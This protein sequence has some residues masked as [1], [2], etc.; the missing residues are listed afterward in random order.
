M[1]NTRYV[2]RMKGA[3]STPYEPLLFST[4]L[5]ALSSSL[6]FLY[7]TKIKIFSSSCVATTTA[8]VGSDTERMKKL[9]ML[10]MKPHQN[11]ARHSRVKFWPVRLGD[12]IA[13]A[14]LLLQSGQ[15]PVQAQFR[16]HHKRQSQEDFVTCQSIVNIVFYVST[17]REWNCSTDLTVSR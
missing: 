8:I 11:L 17:I 2:K 4:S 6:L 16:G 14:Q 13:A 15:A 7:V 10:W 9:E 3:A 1:T 12:Q 5:F